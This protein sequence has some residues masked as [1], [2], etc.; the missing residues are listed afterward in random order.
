MDIQSKNYALKEL[1][2]ENKN[3]F[4]DLNTIDPNVRKYFRAKQARIL[5]KRSDQQQNQQ[6]PPPSTSF[7][8]FGQYFND[9]GGSRDNLPEYLLI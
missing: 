8:L 3:L 9:I 6:A 5:Q 1:K 4:C 2:E 7:G